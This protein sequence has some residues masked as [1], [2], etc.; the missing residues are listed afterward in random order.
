MTRLDPAPPLLQVNEVLADAVAREFADRPIVITAAL[1]QFS[2][3]LKQRYPQLDIDVL[4]TTLNVPRWEDNERVATDDTTATARSSAPLFEIMI[5]SIT[6]KAT[7]AFTSEHFLSDANGRRLNIDIREVESLLRALPG[8]MSAALQ[9]ALTDFWNEPL[10]TG[11]TRWQWLAD[12]C[13]AALL[14]KLGPQDTSSHLDAEQ[15]HTLRQITHCPQKALRLQTYGSGC[16]EA[17]LLQYSAGTGGAV[18]TGAEILVTRTVNGRKIVLAFDPAGDIACFDSLQAFADQRCSMLGSASYEQQMQPW[19]IDTDVFVTLAQAIL[20]AQLGQLAESGETAGQDLARLEASYAAITDTSRCFRSHR[21]TP[22]AQP[23]FNTVLDNPPDW[24]SRATTQDVLECSRYLLE[25][26]ALQLVA[27]G[28]SYD[29]GIETAAVFARNALVKGMSDFSPSVDPDNLL[30]THTR[31]EADAYGSPTGTAIVETDTLTRRALKNLAGLLPGKTELHNRDGSPLP[32][33]V[34]ADT[35]RRLVTQ[36][37]I[38]AQYTQ[39]I[40]QKLIDDLSQKAWREQRFAQLMR[41]QLPLLA[42]ECK[43][44][45]EGGLT[46]AGY[47]QV[48]ALMQPDIAARKLDAQV[49]VIRALSFVLVE[50]E[51]SDEVANMFVIGPRDAERGPHVLYRPL[52][53][54]SLMQ[55][56]SLTAL[57]A[58]IRSDVALEHSMLDWLHPEARK[59]YAHGGFTEPHLAR[60]SIDIDFPT[61]R[62]PAAP[63]LSEEPL[64]GD[65][66]S[67]L[68]QANAKLLLQSADEQ[69]ISNS[70]YRWSTLLGLGERVFDSLLGAVMPYV[71]GPAAAA[72]WLL[73]LER[74][75]LQS[76][77]ALALGDA[78]PARQFLFDVLIQLVLVLLSHRHPVRAV[79]HDVPATSVVR[80]NGPAGRLLATTATTQK[81]PGST[82]DFSLAPPRDTLATLQRYLLAHPEGLGSRIEAPPLPGIHVVDG[83]WYAQVPGRIAGWGWARVAPAEGQNVLMLNPAG[84]PIPWLELRNNGTGLWDTAAEFRV[85]HGGRVSSQLKEYVFGDPQL[86]AERAAR[87]ARLVRLKEQRME[88][89]KQ[90]LHAEEIGNAALLDFYKE[91]MT[92]KALQENVSQSQGK[93]LKQYQRDLASSQQKL[94]IFNQ[95][96][97]KA[98][99]SYVELQLKCIAQL[100]RLGPVFDADEHYLREAKFSCIEEKLVRYNMVE[101]ALESLSS[102]DPELGFE[103]R[104]VFAQVYDDP[105]VADTTPYNALLEARKR[106]LRHY[107]RRV[108]VSQ[109]VEA[110]AAELAQLDQQFFHGRRAV[111]HLEGIKKRR[112]NTEGLKVFELMSIQGA[113]TG[114]P[115][116]EPSM[117]EAAGM[118][119]LRAIPLGRVTSHLLELDTTF[120]F[121]ANERVLLLKDAINH[122]RNAE[123]FAHYL[124]PTDGA[125]SFVPQEFVSKLQERLT[126]YR[127][128]AEEE[129]SRAAHGLEA[130]VAEVEP[131]VKQTKRRRSQKRRVIETP[132]GVLMGESSDEADDPDDAVIATDIYTGRQTTYYRHDEAEPVYQA[133]RDESPEVPKTRPTPGLSKLL[134]DAVALLG[135]VEE[136]KVR[137]SQTGNRSLEPKSQEDTL[138]YQARK[139]DQ[140][141]AA[142]SLRLDEYA[143][144]QLTRAAD[145]KRQLA[146]AAQALREEGVRLRIAGA[147]RLPPTVGNLEYLL[148]KNEVRIGNWNWADKTSATHGPEYLLEFEVLDEKALVHREHAVL[149]F[150]HFHCKTKKAGSVR[151][152]H[153]KAAKLRFKTY[154][155]QLREAQSSQVQAIES[156]NIQKSVAARLFFKYLPPAEQ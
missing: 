118:A 11:T 124:E 121:T 81:M 91:S 17:F 96:K 80:P 151:K 37:D 116:L 43:I 133:R 140:T 26:A 104:Q 94:R 141:A 74:E 35:L 107:P 106:I 62:T 27:D 87:E 92:Y 9:Q 53:T 51:R 114:D 90:I 67:E 138:V 34:T 31:Y 98:G 13:K 41:V 112:L 28:R 71:R 146:L 95:T 150:A 148:Q 76:L 154:A 149:W 126:A 50:V 77:H 49:I 132:D 152:G 1:M 110:T 108:E 19:T 155:D 99:T 23:L 129:L 61:L 105:L 2:A 135:G 14:L 18:R 25:L 70:E 120:G 86:I 72:G 147:R 39:L 55:F 3:A 4:V 119:G 93:E 103:N 8:A 143:A 46:E 12:I 57:L 85:R 84:A 89:D 42:L 60:L 52:Y 127:L 82:L 65:P 44:T 128:K 6:G 136:L 144:E 137:V 130:G 54:P 125:K 10:A 15:C 58:A 139:L 20:D 16:A 38:G 113:L 21:T 69:T 36:A 68:Y 131:G 75:A 32:A 142:L 88:L 5:H 33:W 56:D 78:L 102:I 45:G 122:Y 83:R 156:A 30:I 48:A 59:I 97:L 73:L 24:M 115:A 109:M 101:T 134:K 123:A 117:V 145:L 22:Y 64:S 29:D 79:A 40:K 66:L 153:L 63:V 111:V 47:R 100:D 7:L